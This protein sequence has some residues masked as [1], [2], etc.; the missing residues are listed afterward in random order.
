[1]NTSAGPATDRSASKRHAI[2]IGG[3]MAGLLAA[4]VLVDHF[5]QVTIIDRD[6]FPTTPAHRKGVPH[7]RHGHSLLQ[8]GKEIIDQLF[9]GII[10][11][12]HADGALLA[13]GSEVMRFVTPF[14]ELPRYQAES[15]FCGVS[16]IL[17]EWHVRRRLADHPT[18]RYLT[19]CEVVQ[20]IAD[21][22][23]RRIIGVALHS[24]DEAA[25]PQT[26]HGDLIVDAS[27]RNSHMPEWLAEHG[28]APAPETVVQANI[29]YATRWYKKPVGVERSW[30][31]IIVNGRPPHNPRIGL[32]V[33]VEHQQ[34]T[35]TLGGFNGSY[36]P[37]D[38]QGFLE[39]ARQLADPS[40]FEAIR[41]AEPVSAIYGYR[42]PDNRRRHYE[43]LTRWPSGLIVTGD[44]VCAFNPIY[45][46]G[47]TVSA[48]AAQTLDACLRRQAADGDADF[49]HQFH[50]QL[51]RTV[52]A[53]WLVACRE[54]MRWVDV[55]GIEPP[56]MTRFVHRYMDWILRTACQDVGV[57]YT[58]LGVVNMTMPPTALFRPA[59][60][61]RVGRQ[62]LATLGKQIRRSRRPLLTQ[63]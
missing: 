32:I 19:S 34:W 56:W 11:D 44:A 57:T 41:T 16:R 46:Q 49:A 31:G 12:V 53:P 15:E 2:V 27:G 37:T 7:S 13:N 9:P 23:K 58:Y 42:I 17:V 62:A 50:K 60:V 52:T 4:R 45:G 29:G 14:G 59:I 1:M 36:P 8:R 55:A 47:M 5:E 3:S 63:R 21:A 22:S 33:P 28:Y 43:R 61:A 51:A 38:D 25:A 54:D 48:M 6:S 30:E 18:V 26:L 10:A 20:L 35:V 40:I 24:R 39:Y